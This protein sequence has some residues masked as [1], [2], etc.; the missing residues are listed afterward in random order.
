VTQEQAESYVGKVVYVVSGGIVKRWRVALALQ[1]KREHSSE[2]QSV[3]YV[4][5]VDGKEIAYY[6]PLAT[7]EDTATEL[8]LKQVRAANDEAYE[9]IDRYE[10]REKQLCDTRDR[11]LARKGLK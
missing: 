6:Y 8:A 1:A 10:E 3:W 7:D 9:A 4:A 2:R 11:R 5:D